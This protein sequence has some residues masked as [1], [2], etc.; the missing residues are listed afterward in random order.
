MKKALT[1]DINLYDDA[2]DG[3][4]IGRRDG[5]FSTSL[6]IKDTDEYKEQILVV[7]DNISRMFESCNSI[8]EAFEERL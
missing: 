2:T 1:I 3:K 5:M 6:T 8:R 7:L 4:R